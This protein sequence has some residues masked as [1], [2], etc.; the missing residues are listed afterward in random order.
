MKIRT[1]ILPDGEE[2]IVIKCKDRT[3]RIMALESLIEKAV[4]SQGD[5][6]LYIS[7]TEYYVSKNDI[8][9]FE[10]NDGKVYAHT[11]SRI[12]TSRYR[13]FEIEQIMPSYFIRISKSAI[14]NTKMISSLKRELTGNGE[15]GF[16]GCEKKVYFSRGYYKFLHDKIEETRLGI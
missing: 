10:T 9:F 8:L 6:P 12:F 14:A 7:N 3:D 1:E 4:K 16:R 5:I 11:K 15:I 13:L 2:E